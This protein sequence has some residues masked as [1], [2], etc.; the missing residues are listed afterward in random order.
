MNSNT[1]FGAQAL[2]VWP[3]FFRPFSAGLLAS[4]SGLE[5]RG[6]GPYGL[7]QKVSFLNL[8]MISMCHGR[9]AFETGL[10]TWV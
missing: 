6:L 7:E 1:L 3:G 2:G 10:L 9:K 8:S 5:F 4:S